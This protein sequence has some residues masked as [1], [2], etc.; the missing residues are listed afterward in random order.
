M[1]EDLFL[2]TFGDEV[3]LRVLMCLNQNGSGT[4]YRIAKITGLERPTVKRSLLDLA[5]V[6]LV[7]RRNLTHT[8]KSG[9]WGPYVTPKL[10][11]TEYAFN[12]A[13]EAAHA[14]T[15]LFREIA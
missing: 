10:A 15:S 2:S 5:A 6:N 8:H 14:L 11:V 9:Q 1:R 12:G 3:N 13:H 4:V 7:E